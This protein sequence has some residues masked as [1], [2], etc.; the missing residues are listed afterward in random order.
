MDTKGIET[1]RR[2]N[3]LLVRQVV[4]TCLTKILMD[5]DIPGAVKY[6]QNT[7]SDLLMNKL[8]LSLLV[9]TKGLT[10]TADE[11]AVKAAHAELAQRMF[12]RDPATA[13]VVG[14]RVAYVMIKATKNAKGYEKS[15]CPI[16]AMDNNLPIDHKHYLDN[17]LTNLCCVCSNRFY[18][19]PHLFSS[20]V[21]TPGRSRYLP[22]LPP[23]PAASSLAKVRPSRRLPRTNHGREALQILCKHCVEDEFKH[24]QKALVTV[25][26]LEKDF[27]RLW[28]QC[29]RCQGC[30]TKTSCARRE[31]VRF[32]TEEGKR[33]KI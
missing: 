6:V 22:R 17:F 4:E 20:L 26:E 30:C 32:F 24:L 33:R 11:Y 7:I 18:K 29:Q 21:N 12:L 10:K 31:T 15:E 23:W 14:D 3:C 1:V 8:D 28:T 19:T 13:P 16:Y 9:I 2:D 25:N 27:N 5:R